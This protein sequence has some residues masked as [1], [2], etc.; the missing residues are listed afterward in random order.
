M[1]TVTPIRVAVS[2]A[3]GRIGYSLVFR[4][5]AGGLFGPEQP[6]VLSLLEL[7]EA[8]AGLEACALELKDCAFPLL[9]E[10]R[11]GIDSREAFHGA[12]WII[13]LGGKPFSIDLANRLDLLRNN[14]PTMVEHGRAINQTAPSRASSWW[15]SPATRIA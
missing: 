2:G 14:A 10:L 5:A 9:A 11:I 7:P 3:A 4:I 12:D 13:L 15:R 6:V 8:R 1:T